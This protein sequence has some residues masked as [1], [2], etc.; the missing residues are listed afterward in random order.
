MN[1]PESASGAW[2]HSADVARVDS[3]ELQ[4]RAVL[5]LERLDQPAVILEGGALLVHDLV[6]G[7][8]DTEAIIAILSER[9][10]EVHDLADQVRDTLEQLAATGIVGTLS[11][12]DAPNASST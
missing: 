11:T 5:N 12:L 9:H 1:T 4:R 3:P 8:R 6:D 2:R 7:A 10:R